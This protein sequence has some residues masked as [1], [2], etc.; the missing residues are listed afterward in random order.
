[1]E[2]TWSPPDKDTNKKLLE[3]VPG[4]PGKSQSE[5]KEVP[6]IGPL[7]VFL[8]FQRPPAYL[9]PVKGSPGSNSEFILNQSLDSHF[10]TAATATSMF[11]QLSSNAACSSSLAVI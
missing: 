3:G 2:P 8:L 9:Q 7:I 10:P 4:I 6:L 1:M 11:V 5:G